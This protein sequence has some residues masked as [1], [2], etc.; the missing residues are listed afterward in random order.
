MTELNGFPSISMRK[1]VKFPWKSWGCGRLDR[2]FRKRLL[3]AW[4]AL[5]LSYFLV[6]SPGHLSMT[7]FHDYLFSYWIDDLL[8][9][10]FAGALVKS[11]LWEVVRVID[12]SA[13]GMVW[14]K[15]ATYE[16]KKYISM[17]HRDI[18]FSWYSVDCV[19]SVLY[20]YYTRLHNKPQTN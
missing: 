2:K 20:I 17:V 14:N 11:L 4:V 15:I 16:G 13:R 18:E 3:C 10:F 5:D 19:I 7:L 12:L 9:Y 1:D 6:H 8:F